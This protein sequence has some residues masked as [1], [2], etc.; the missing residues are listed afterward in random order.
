MVLVISK[1]SMTLSERLKLEE[2]KFT[3]DMR[4][5]GFSNSVVC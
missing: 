4:K 5:N 1:T 3:K 2:I